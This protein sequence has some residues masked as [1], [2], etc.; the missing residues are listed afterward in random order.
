MRPSFHQI[1]SDLAADFAARSQCER[2]SVGCV[3]AS[4]NGS[5]VFSVGYNGGPA[6][7]RRK[8]RGK[9]AVGACGCAHAETNAIAK[10]R[11]AR[12]EGKIVYVTDMPCELCAT[13]L[14]NMGGVLRVHWVRDYRLRDGEE[15]LLEAGIIARKLDLAEM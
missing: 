12:R 4:E 7:S 9:D 5:E 6:R 8:C 1:Y 2:L 14:V 13:L 3:I 15:I 11:A 10:C